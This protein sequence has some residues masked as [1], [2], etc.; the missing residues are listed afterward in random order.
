MQGSERQ[1]ND[2]KQQKTIA[3]AEPPFYGVLFFF[4]FFVYFVSERTEFYADVLCSFETH[5]SERLI[6]FVLELSN[7]IR[8]GFGRSKEVKFLLSR[9][10]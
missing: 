10:I 9:Q 3:R 4:F 8:R 1:K 7:R 6:L 5:K 2:S